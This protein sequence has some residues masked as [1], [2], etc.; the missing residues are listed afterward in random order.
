MHMIFIYQILKT[1]KQKKNLNQEE[2]NLS[3]EKSQ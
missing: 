1:Q 3:K 2:P